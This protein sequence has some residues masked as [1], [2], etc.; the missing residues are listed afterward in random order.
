MDA[1]LS[2]S[3]GR[4]LSRARCAGCEDVNVHDLLEACAQRLGL[5]CLPQGKRHPR[6]DVF[7]PWGGRVLV[8]LFHAPGSPEGLAAAAAGE[9][10]RPVRPLISS[11]EKL[12]LAVAREIPTL[13]GRAPRLAYLEGMRAKHRDAVERHAKGQRGQQRM[14][15]AEMKAAVKKNMAARAAAEAQGILGAGGGQAVNSMD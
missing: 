10:R 2:T 4:R 6:A 13:P 12:L 14:S 7:Q 8:E 9:A 5:P 11:K 1:R 15:K 3:Q